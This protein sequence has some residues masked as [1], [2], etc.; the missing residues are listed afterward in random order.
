MCYV[1]RACTGL[2]CRSLGVHISKVRSIT[3]DDWET[4]HQKVTNL[5]M[6]RSDL[7]VQYMSMS[8]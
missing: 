5:G 4:E 3:L 8:M 7:H 2:L 6:E 1:M